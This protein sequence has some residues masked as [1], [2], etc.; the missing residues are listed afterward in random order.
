MA[1]PNACHG[2]R[3]FRRGNHEVRGDWVQSRNRF[4]PGKHRAG[5]NR[6]AR[7]RAVSG[8]SR[9]QRQAAVGQS[10]AGGRPLLS[11]QPAHF[12]RRPP[13]RHAGHR[14]QPHD[15]LDHFAPDPADGIFDDGG[16]LRAGAEICRLRQGDPAGQVPQAGLPLDP[17]RHRGDTGCRP[18]A[19]QGGGRDRRIHPPGAQGAQGP[20]G[21]H[22]PGGREPGLFRFHRA[23]ALECQPGRHRR[24]HGG[25]GGQGDRR[26]RHE[27]S[28]RRPAGRVH[29]ALQRGAGLHQVP[30][31]KPDSGGDA[32]PGRP[33][34][35][36]GNGG[37]RRKM[38]HRELHVGQL[39]HP[40]QGFLERGRR[41]RVDRNHEQGPHPADQLLQLPD[42][43]RGD[44]FHA[45]AAHL[46]DEVLHQADLHDGGLLESGFRAAHRP[47]RHRV[48]RNRRRTCSGVASVA[49]SKSLGIPPSSR[50]RTAPPTR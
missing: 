1:H 29:A 15:R 3:C 45:G 23:G 22:R 24:R 12:R 10:P 4:V 11:R 13:V 27:G 25:Q 6:P 33:G 5:R 43:L 36:P 48:R 8:R 39:A 17:Q 32:D 47:A 2:F 16:L 50:S 37:P 31:R 49:T 38:A 7:D 42:D 14:L 44:H 28:Q 41:R 21:R 26:P 46:H 40:A 20:G 30:Q 35:P 34:I 18:P 9:D 19:G